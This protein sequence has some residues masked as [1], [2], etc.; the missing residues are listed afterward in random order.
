MR[1]AMTLLVAAACFAAVGPAA[2]AQ[3]QRVVRAVMHQ[4]PPFIIVGHTPS[5]YAIEVL[6]AVAA[7]RGF[8]IKY[9]VVD[10]PAEALK[11]IAAGGADLHPSLG[12][13]E[14]RRGVVD[15]SRPYE[16]LAFGL[17]TREAE[18]ER[19][20]DESRRSDMVFGA[21]AGTVPAGILA[22]IEGPAHK[23]L[24]DNNATLF[25]LASGEI[26]AAVYGV[27]AF[28]SL[29]RSIGVEDTFTQVGD[30][31]RR[32]PV[33]IAVSN[34][35]PDLLEMIND[36]LISVMASQDFARIRQH[37]FG[38][39]P[40]YWDRKRILAWGGGAFAFLL[41][42]AVGALLRVRDAERRRRL[43]EALRFTKKLAAAN[44]DLEQRNEEMRRLVY[45]VSH[46]LNSPLASIGGF[47]R[48]L[49]RGIEKGDDD[50]VR[51]SAQRI[52]RNITTMRRLLDGVLV[53]NRASSNTLLRER[54]QCSMLVQSTR[55]ALAEALRA[56]S[57]TLNL[58]VETPD[59][60]CD[61]ML[62]T[63]SVQN[64]VENALRHGCPNPGM[65]VT[66]RIERVGD[67]VRIIVY[68]QGPGIPVER[69]DEVFRP[70][71]RGPEARREGKEGLGIGLA[72]VKAVVE[73]HGGRLWVEQQPCAGARF[74]IELPQNEITAGLMEREVS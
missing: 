66:L 41:F 18:K 21:T 1:W 5:G 71:M 32:I 19:V 2:R 53:L 27:A 61:A 65:T 55:D 54:M 23:L 74:V 29:V 16:H 8:T 64:L 51:D 46:D 15:F 59:L 56:K 31:L 72:T 14:S 6:E 12:P 13:E 57:A 52:S 35:A 28:R 30:D 11:I 3:E 40:P 17:F 68:D 58:E 70:F 34:A 20:E 43:E 60:I 67:A 69:R 38:A 9:L 39:P 37:W 24:N 62:I 26:D 49:T 47:A 36:G 42:A 10:N 22:G 73:K 63:Q 44:L 4:F 48:R 25:A 33:T 7:D 50:I 45:M